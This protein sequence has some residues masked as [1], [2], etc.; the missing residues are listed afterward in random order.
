VRGREPTFGRAEM[1]VRA[2]A[3]EASS[4]TGKFLGWWGHEL[5]G[6]V[7]A[8]VRALLVPPSTRLLIEIHKMGTLK[9]TKLSASG[10]EE[11]MTVRPRTDGA[12]EPEHSL[13]GITEDVDS[14][15]ISLPE[16]CGVRRRVVL[17]AAARENLRE[18]LTMEMDRLTP[19]KADEI[20]FAH[21][22]PEPGRANDQISVEL[23]I[24]PKGL[25]DD[26]MRM[27]RSLGIE[28][29]VLVL[30]DD[31]KFENNL[32]GGPAAAKRSP[33]IRINS[34]TLVAAL[35]MVIAV[36]VPF[37]KQAQALKNLQAKI[38]QAGSAGGQAEDIERRLS[39][40]QAGTRR[41]ADFR[42]HNPAVVQVL[43]ELSTTIPKMTWLTEIDVSAEPSRLV[44][45][46]YSSNAPALIAPLEALDTLQGVKFDQPV[47]FDDR[48]SRDRFQTSADIVAANAPS[49]ERHR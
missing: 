25:A 7:P 46:G 9:L 1:D 27:A 11:L 36:A 23:T 39:A 45:S 22:N 34:F 5:G 29:D 31:G 4:N 42:Q 24:V 12:P 40:W 28:P 38:E 43:N 33:V 6:C 20:Y 30:G 48:Q 15:V 41:V 26:V 2:L 18:V 47:S 35:L 21:S 10:H 19:F 37:A 44:I 14:V 32:L 49:P 16:S 8:S 13:H 3:A 17:P